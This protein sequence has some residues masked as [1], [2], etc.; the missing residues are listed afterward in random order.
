M[1]LS[2]SIQ[3]H[4]V[5]QFTPHSFDGVGVRRSVGRV[6]EVHRMV[7]GEMMVAFI[8]QTVVGLPTVGNDGGTR[9]NP[10]LDDSEKSGP[11]SALD[12]Y[13][14]TGSCFTT[15]ATEHPL[16]INYSANIILPLAKFAL[17][18]F[19]NFS[20][21]TDLA[22]SLHAPFHQHFPT[23]T[24]PVANTFPGQAQFTV[25]EHI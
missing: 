7:N 11:V 15:Q 5:L 10:L 23:K 22:F 17:V 6:H 4:F 8:V 21:T 12:G 16:T 24:C 3:R 18:Y 20:W 14:E 25:D 2:P 1:F 13:H 19:H 9:L